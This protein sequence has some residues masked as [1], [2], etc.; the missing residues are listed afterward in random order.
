MPGVLSTLAQQIS[1]QAIPKKKAPWETMVIPF[2]KMEPRVVSKE[3][4][5]SFKLFSNPGKKDSST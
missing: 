1:D 5:L 4:R 3:D 2:E